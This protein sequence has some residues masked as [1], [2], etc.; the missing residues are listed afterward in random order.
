M[1]IKIK[2]DVATVI[3]VLH[4]KLSYATFSFTNDG[5]LFVDSDWGFYGHRWPNPGIPMKD[6]L[7]SINEEYFINKLEINHF[8][9]TGK[10]IVN[11]RKKALSELFKE[12][13]NYLKSDGKI[14]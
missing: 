1:K 13:Q 7:I 3:T 11:T 2:E 8:N 5:I 12:F 10:K 9:E 14:L 4:P 6:F